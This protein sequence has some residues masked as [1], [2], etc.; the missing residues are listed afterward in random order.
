MVT[1][2]LLMIQLFVGAALPFESLAF[3]NLVIFIAAITLLGAFCALCTR[4]ELEA[5][6]DCFRLVVRLFCAPIISRMVR[7]SSWHLVTRPGRSID[8]MTSEST[9]CRVEVTDHEGNRSLVMGEVIAFF[10]GVEC[11]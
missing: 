11:L 1:F 10:Y 9:F 4:L 2:A 3:G 8:A 7:G 6:G 5:D